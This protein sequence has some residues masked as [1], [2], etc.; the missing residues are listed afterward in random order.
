MARPTSGGDDK[1]LQLVEEIARDVNDMAR[2][3]T[4]G[5]GASLASASSAGGGRSGAGNFRGASTGGGVSLGG[6]GN[7]TRGITG[8]LGGGLAASVAGG[9]AGMAAGAAA[10]VSRNVIGTGVNE[11]ANSFIN[12]NLSFSDAISYGAAKG[13]SKIPFVGG[14]IASELSAVE[15]AGARV[16]GVL[17]PLA[18]AGADPKLLDAAQVPLFARFAAQ[19]FRANARNRKVDAMVQG[20]GTNQSLGVAGTRWL[21]RLGIVP[22]GLSGPPSEKMISDGLKASSRGQYRRGSE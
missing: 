5:G 2:T 18:R 12:N 14:T 20:P 16:K 10:N 22:E 7:I 1:L 17:T 4:V 6:A 11:A 8:M 19:E 15:R 21:E 9:A 13:V 3:R